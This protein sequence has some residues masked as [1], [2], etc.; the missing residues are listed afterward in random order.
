LVQVEPPYEIKF[1][2]REA[3]RYNILN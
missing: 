3:R 2:E 1:A